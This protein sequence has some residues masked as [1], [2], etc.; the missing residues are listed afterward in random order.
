MAS[1]NSL[2]MRNR[3]R[4]LHIQDSIRSIYLTILP[5]YRLATFLLNLSSKYRPGHKLIKFDIDFPER[6]AKSPD[7]QASLMGVTRQAV[8]NLWIAERL[9]KET[10]WQKGWSE[11]P[12]SDHKSDDTRK[13]TAEGD[14][15]KIQ[16]IMLKNRV[17][18]KHLFISIYCISLSGLSALFSGCATYSQLDKANQR[19]SC[20][21]SVKK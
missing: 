17:C 20:L 11:N 21:G 9:R 13:E 12:G 4:K 6:M 8:I 19:L 5:N 1:H 16:E 15:M 10:A 7:F 2:A 14:A 18:W 3:K